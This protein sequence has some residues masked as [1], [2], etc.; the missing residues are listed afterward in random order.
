[1]LTHDS[2]LT[3]EV[4]V[5]L[6]GYG[7]GA[8][9]D[10]ML[11]ADGRLRPGWESVLASLGNLGRDGLIARAEEVQRLLYDNGVTFNMHG[12]T[13][14]RGW[15]IDP[16][17]LVVGME[18]WQR[19][20]AGLEQRSRLLSAI[21]TDLYGPRRLLEEGLLPPELILEHSGFLLA[22]DQTLANGRAGLI[23]HGIDLVRDAKG[24]WRVMTDRLQ[25]PS[26]TGFAL[27]NRILLARAMPEVYRDAPLRRL[28]GF[29]EADHR[30]L[31]AQARHHR[32]HPTLVLL[33]PGP[34][35]PRYFEHAY[36]ANY[37]NVSLVEGLDL[38][39]RDAQVWI[40]TLG[41]LKPV[42]VILRQL[43]DRWC[44]PL[45]LRGDSSLGVPG[46]LQAVRSGGVAMSNALGV[47]VLEHPGL[48]PYLSTLC[49]H[50]LD[51][52][53]R[54]AG[55]ESG[56]C[57][58]PS[59]L[60]WALADFDELD[61]RETEPGA[62]AISPR[63][64]ASAQAAALRQRIQATPSRF[65]AERPVTPSTTPVFDAE[66]RRLVPQPLNL[67]CFTTLDPEGEEP[68]GRAP[69]R[70]MPGGLAWVGAPGT[71]SLQSEVVKDVWVM[72]SAPQPHISQLRQA[73]G[74]IVTT[75]DGDD[76]PS[77][78]ADSLFWV[79]RYGER[80]DARTRLLRE[81]LLHLLEYDQEGLTDSILA[82]LFVV[83]EMQPPAAE[84]SPRERF[85]TQRAH[86]LSLF[87]V[88]S[89]LGLPTIFQHM[90]RNARA[91]RDHLGDD[92]WRTLN[93][94]RQRIASFEQ[95]PAVGAGR[96]AS[97]DVISQLAAFFGLCNETMP[98]HYG[99]RFMDIGRFIE[100]ILSLLA[101]LRL[102]LITARTPGVPL[103]EVVLATTDNFTAYRRRYRG[104]LHPT[105][106]LD[107]LLF[108]EGN[109]R[110]VGYMLKRLGRQIERLP[111]PEGTPYRS[112]ET[113]LI[114]RATSTLHLADIASLSE[115]DRSE[116]AHQALEALIDAL[117]VPLSTLS[118]AISHSH[119][120]H[121]ESPHQLLK[122]Q[123]Q[124]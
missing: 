45:E 121:S 30:T 71:P 92:S 88:E 124:P 24:E 72:A 94:L 33:T 61:F 107:L 66:L 87:D 51:E 25:A 81:A 46:L 55:P 91:V 90:L 16:L 1:M 82:D 110:S 86:L 60:E 21:L 5:L 48:A 115:L 122:M 62:L 36:L 109:P 32:E 6:Q 23:F 44:D 28:A 114:I 73:T 98:H 84:G 83:L 64:L 97:E 118:D 17:P 34:G 2:L 120:S 102:A 99:W 119:L 13:L 103:W 11:A 116:Q 7:G 113:R 63:E 12:D 65:V 42:D 39:V 80:L 50:L 123:V 22:C 52:P 37:L 14:G 108:D 4:R 75:R 57:G 70:V 19:L 112:V 54:L 68:A 31:V 27:E 58:E 78:V 40:R 35:S 85:A 15:R 79:G 38:V 43:D 49:Q 9:F 106:I 47:G 53:L 69:Y 96:R 3:P 101:L 89:T 26:G 93:Q 95:M 29:H 56:W 10:A 8:G 105:A 117:I 41:G 20:E 18:E 76:M 77:R 59:A 104:E 74:P 67:R 100:R 111:Q